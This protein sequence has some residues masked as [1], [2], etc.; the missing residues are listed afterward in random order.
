MVDDDAAVQVKMDHD[1]WQGVSYAAA[2][3]KVATRNVKESSSYSY[4][5]NR[6]VRYPTCRNCWAGCLR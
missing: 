1:K 3:Q 2:V 6:P 5:G 4:A